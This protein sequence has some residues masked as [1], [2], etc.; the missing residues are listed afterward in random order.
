[1]FFLGLFL[2]MKRHRWKRKRRRLRGRW[3]KQLG[4]ASGFDLGLKE[5]GKQRGGVCWNGGR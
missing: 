4:F 5:R 1:M 2:V 3:G